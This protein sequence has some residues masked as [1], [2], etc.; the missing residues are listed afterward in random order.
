MRK[1]ERKGAREGRE[2]GRERTGQE[3]CNQ[4]QI[5]WPAASQRVKADGAGAA[6]AQGMTEV[7]ADAAVVQVE[8][9]VAE[10]ESRNV[11]R[12]AEKAGSAAA[13]LSV[14]GLWG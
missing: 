10:R 4:R 12:A 7:C 8:A 1:N 6:V 5:C 9:V 2:R 14:R 11:T 13:A 3:V